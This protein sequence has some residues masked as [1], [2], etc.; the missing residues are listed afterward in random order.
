[1]DVSNIINSLNQAQREA[2][3]S[4]GQHQLILAGAGSGKTRVLIHRMAWIIDVLQQS[5]AS[6]LM[7]TFTN[8]AAKE[9]RHRVEAML[10][11]QPRGM[12]IGTFHGLGHRLLQMHHQEVNLPASFQVLDSDDQLRIVKRV[13][14]EMNLDEKRWVPKSAQ[15]FIN[16]QKEEGIRADNVSVNDYFTQT[17]Q[18][19]YETYQHYCDR[20]GVVDFAEI[21]LRTHELFLNN[22]SVLEHYQQRFK[23]IMVDEFQDTNTIQYAWL[24]LLSVDNS[25]VVV[26]D[27]DQSIYGWRGAKIENILNFQQDFTDTQITRLEQNYRSTNVILQA[28]NAIIEKNHQRLGKNLWT[29]LGEGELIDIYDASDE[30]D[31]AAFIA[32]YLQQWYRT[33]DESSGEKQLKDIAILY[34]SNAQSRILEEVMIRNKIPYQ[35]YGGQRFYE[36]LEIK[37]VVAYLRLLVNENDDNALERVIN[38]PPRG[39]GARSMEKI[40]DHARAMNQ[41]LWQAVSS[42]VQRNMFSA[43]SHNALEDFMLLI[44]SL[45]GASKQLA[46]H[47]VVEEVIART[48]LKQFHASEGGE[49]GAA[50]VEN[51][52]ELVN[53][54]HN[55]HSSDDNV[56]VLVQFLAEASLDAGD[57]QADSN[58]DAVQM[59]TLH[60]AKGLEFP[61]VILAGV[62]NNLFPHMMAEQEG[63]HE[64][65]RRLCYVGITR[66]MRKL[67]MSYAQSRRL[68][69]QERYNG[70]S[71]FIREIPSHLLC[72]VR[73]GS[74]DTANSNASQAADKVVSQDELLPIG[75]QVQHPVF[76][77]GMIINYEGS[78][79]HLRVEVN[80]DNEGSKWL[81]YAYARL[82]LVN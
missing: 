26:G 50:R 69:G 34:R 25:V 59:M 6:I 30:Y 43:K 33:I 77:V 52:E 15:W 82:Q 24:R 42:M 1:M 10:N 74:S 41:S 9:L 11:I 12:W 79:E 22:P 36:R 68:H 39:I 13:I 63:N 18:Q 49:R 70:A 46:L 31:E 8:K 75:Q 38:V 67:L 28:A 21:L 58:Q 17:H 48:D 78:G 71:I 32:N 4:Q 72:R 76:G 51:I 73:L 16:S 80:F 61:L 47:E 23:H 19:I 40:R 57:Q 66:A 45:T 44:Q 60:S 55:F 37:N 5:P 62:E 81:I 3:T 54:C 53:A 65:E 56:S 14:R 27:D 2:V 29:D 35:I 7:V 20:I 64:E